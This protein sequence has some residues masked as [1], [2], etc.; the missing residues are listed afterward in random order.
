MKNYILKAIVIFSFCL[1]AF[2]I[3]QGFK[4]NPEI[5]SGNNY[6]SIILP[7]TISNPHTDFV[8]AIFNIH[9]K[10]E[11]HMLHV[12]PW[13]NHIKDSLHF[14]TVQVYGGA[15]SDGS[16]RYGI[17]GEI[18]TTTQKDN[19]I[20]LMDSVSELQLKGIY[21]RINIEKMCYGQRLEYEVSGS[22]STTV[23]DGFCYQYIMSNTYTTDGI[24]TVLKPAPGTHTAGVLCENIFENFQHTDLYDYVQNDS[25]TWF[26]KPVMKID[27]NIVDTDLHKEIVK[28]L[29]TNYEGDTVK[30]VT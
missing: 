21:G 5:K 27:S 28:I 3:I 18:L 12:S 23:N 10:P 29:I 30:S 9:Y 6:S 22:G 2:F 24:R 1:S 19:M 26:V 17:F 15:Q 4:G 11:E 20:D 8:N 7:P 25:G 13:L 16:D 14:N